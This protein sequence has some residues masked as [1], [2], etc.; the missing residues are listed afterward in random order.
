[1]TYLDTD[2]VKLKN[3]NGVEEELPKWQVSS[4]PAT[5]AQQRQ[6][7]AW[8]LG[9]A[10]E[11]VMTS[12]YYRFAGR[13]YRQCQGGPIGL[14]LTQALARIVM[15]WWD[16]QFLARCKDINIDMELY[17]RYVDDLDSATWALPAGT[18]YTSGGLQ[19]DPGLEELE[20]DD[21]PDKITA[22]VLRELANS[23]TPMVKMVEDYPSNH[24][25]GR[26]PILDL[27]VWV[28]DGTVNH[29]FYKKPVASKFVVSA[30]S[31]FPAAKKRA[32]LVEEGVRRLRNNSPEL[33]FVWKAQF[34]TELALEMQNS[35]HRPGFR[36]MV[37]D[38]ATKKYQMILNKHQQGEDMYRTRANI[39][40]H[41]QAKGGIAARERYFRRPAG[42]GG[43][44]FTATLKVPPSPGSELKTALQRALTQG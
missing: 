3:E 37:L 39:M 17:K 14:E 40:A 19:V 23:I 8:A 35:G 26:L 6:M 18:V 27:E 25:T 13:V 21:Q 36:A 41:K 30:Q 29:Q 42:Q 24:P 1:L 43:Q 28:E 33:P 12:H 32:V 44:R 10:V 20:R 2:K 4:T 15:L 9:K 5:P 34:L 11:A 31:A 16:G 22:R 38:A 7:L